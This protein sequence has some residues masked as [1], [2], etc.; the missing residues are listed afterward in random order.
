[1]ARVRE[2]KLSP[3]DE[4]ALRGMRAVT[5]RIQSMSRRLI[6]A[7]C[8]I[9][10]SGTI[11]GLELVGSSVLLR[12]GERS[13]LITAAHVLDHAED[14]HL[15]AGGDR[16]F[17]DLGGEQLATR[18]PESGRDDDPFDLAIFPLDATQVSQLGDSLFLGPQDLAPAERPDF[19][20]V[21]GSKYLVLGYPR[22]AQPRRQAGPDLGAFPGHLALTPRPLA[23]YGPRELAPHH[24]LLLDF[25]RDNMVSQ[26]GQVTGRHPRGMSGGGIWD[27]DLFGLRAGHRE[28]LVAVMTEYREDDETVIGSRIGLC[29]DALRDRYPELDAVLPRP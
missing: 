18:R 15:F 1:M 12:F 23:D 16:T 20:P 9:Y 22:T 4:E 5:R 26:R 25:E 17:V 29:I 24:H 28:R 2:P 11:G 21:R 19:T 3:P 10:G 13:F 27:V 8:P 7:V 6:A 14:G